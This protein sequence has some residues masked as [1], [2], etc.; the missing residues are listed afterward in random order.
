MYVVSG[1]SR[2]REVC[3]KADATS[4][5]KNAG[6]THLGRAGA[7]LVAQGARNAHRRQGSPEGLRYS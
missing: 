7:P 3:L 6:A 1:F 2:A 5:P 4:K